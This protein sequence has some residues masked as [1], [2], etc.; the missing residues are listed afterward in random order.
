[1]KSKWIY[2][3]ALFFGLLTS[4]FIYDFLAKVEK[5]ATEAK[6]EEIVVA[7]CNV[8][9]KT[10]LTRE[11][12]VL[13]KVPVEGIHAQ[14][15]RKTEEAVGS[16]TLTSLVESEQLLKSKLTS[17]DNAKNGLAYIIPPDK[18]A[19]S[20]PIDEVSGVANLLEPGDNVDVAAVLGLV[21][22][23][24]KETTY[25]LIVLQDIQILAIGKKLDEKNNS[26]ESGQQEQK[27]VTLAVTVEEAQSLFMANQKGTLRLLLRSP[28]DD[29]IVAAA[30]YKQEDL[31]NARGN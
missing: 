25:S 1:M 15:L 26:K 3:G 28:I 31:L 16:I 11:M 20:I 21:D 24:G 29:S 6:T 9:A 10:L 22:S 7:A 30:P 23:T 19:M 27:T 18:R 12:L 14:A 17:K 13:K 4:Y 2:A 8:P 5:S